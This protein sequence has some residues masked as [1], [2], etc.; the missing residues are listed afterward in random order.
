MEDFKFG[1]NWLSQFGGRLLQKPKIEIAQKAIELIEVPGRDGMVI[2]DL[3]FYRNV[4]FDRKIGFLSTVT[5]KASRDLIDSL[6][7]WLTYCSGY[8]EFRDTQ[9]NGF[10]T[11]AVLTN[12]SAIERELRIY[13]TATL[14]FNRIPFWYDDKGQ[15]VKSFIINSEKNSIELFN[16]MLAEA[17]YTMR[18]YTETTKVAIVGININ[19]SIYYFY[20]Q[21]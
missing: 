21:P 12:I 10:F 5:D 1:N 9:H 14:K 2:Q 13:S 6:I 4:E 3:G 7:D 18:I 8:Q 15:T 16:P 20:K 11:K 19:N 17:Q